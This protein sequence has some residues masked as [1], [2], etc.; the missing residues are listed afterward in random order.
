MEIIIIANPFLNTKNEHLGWNLINSTFT[1]YDESTVFILGKVIKLFDIKNSYRLKKVSSLLSVG[2]L[3]FCKTKTPFMGYIKFKKDKETVYVINARTKIGMYL[4]LPIIEAANVINC[5][6]QLK[7]LIPSCNITKSS[8]FMDHKNGKA[9]GIRL[10]TPGGLYEAFYS[11]STNYGEN[12]IYCNKKLTRLSKQE[13]LNLFSTLNYKILLNNTEDKDMWQI[14]DK[15]K[16]IFDFKTFLMSLGYEY[17]QE[18][19]K[20]QL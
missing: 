14:E 18:D 2:D 16:K 10:D 11:L 5:L 17:K 15:N 6:S 13:I 19:N 3:V 12:V 9:S 7:S 4:T 1:S 8:I 20:C